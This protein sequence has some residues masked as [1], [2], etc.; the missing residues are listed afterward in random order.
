MLEE[1]TK[2][3]ASDLQVCV[4]TIHDLYLSRRG[5]GLEAV[6]NKYKHHKFKCVATMPVS[7]ELPH[8]FFED[9]TIREKV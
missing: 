9:V 8:A 6:R 1:Y 4:G 7:P 3:K 5:I 2:Y